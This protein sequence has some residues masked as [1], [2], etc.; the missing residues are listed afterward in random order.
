MCFF[1][2]TFVNASKMYFW[3][4]PWYMCGRRNDFLWAF[5]TS[6]LTSDQGSA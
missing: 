1:F 3:Y 4:T 6:L 5:I 2:F